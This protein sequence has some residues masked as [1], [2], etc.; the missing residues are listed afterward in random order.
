M[1][2]VLFVSVCPEWLPFGVAL[3]NWAARRIDGLRT[4]AS[5]LRKKR[6]S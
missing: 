4:Q 5:S 6:K 1:N 3:K 2:F